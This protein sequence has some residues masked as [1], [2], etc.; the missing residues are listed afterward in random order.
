[1]KG[2]GRLSFPSGIDPTYPWEYSHAQSTRGSPR[3]RP[4]NIPLPHYRSAIC[5]HPLYY[6]QALFSR[7]HVP[8]LLHRLLVISSVLKLPINDQ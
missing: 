8:Y 5:R 7:T 6:K 4:M 1:M 3:V 2:F